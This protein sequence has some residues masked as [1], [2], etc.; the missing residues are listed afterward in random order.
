MSDVKYL[1][2][3]SLKHHVELN[4]CESRN[5][6]VIL[7]SLIFCKMSF[8]KNITFSFSRDNKLLVSGTQDGDLILWSMETQSVNQHLPSMS[9]FFYEDLVYFQAQFCGDSVSSC[10]NISF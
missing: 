5:A 9:L 7:Y 2:G 8:M 3:T 1:S 6:Y 4:L 10:Y